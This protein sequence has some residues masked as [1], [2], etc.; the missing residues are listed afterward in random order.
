MMS[1]RSFD[2]EERFD[3]FCSV[4]RDD[5]CR[6]V[7]ADVD[8]PSPGQDAAFSSTDP[9]RLFRFI[10]NEC[11]TVAATAASYA[12]R[13]GPVSVRGSEE[14]HCIQPDHCDSGHVSPRRLGC[15]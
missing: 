7:S 3:W 14:L 13:T 5:R 8:S 15:G 6:D 4:V 10:F 1:A 11:G 12:V 2:F 9:G